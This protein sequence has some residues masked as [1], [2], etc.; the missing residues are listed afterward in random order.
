MTE[1]PNRRQPDDAFSVLYE[2]LAPQV[3]RYLLSRTPTA[4][5]AEELVSTI[6]L[7]AFT[8]LSS[9]NG[10]GQRSFQGWVM[11]IAHNQLAN[12]YRD[13]GRRPILGSLE[14]QESLAVT[15]PS[16]ETLAEKHEQLNE[17][18]AAVSSL[19][20]S[21]Q[22][23]ITLKY[24]QGLTNAQIGKHMNKTEGAIKQ[25]NRRTLKALEAILDSDIH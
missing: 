4:D 10:S 3:Y 13:T 18:R 12:W 22:S 15:T 19:P 25:L 17:L 8:A 1:N 9:F 6:F 20:E 24:M 21:Q 2:T 14:D 5:I 16:A 23:L 7:R 11:T